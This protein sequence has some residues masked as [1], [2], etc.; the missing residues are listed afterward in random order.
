M[1]YH[2]RYHT[3]VCYEGAV[4]RILLEDALEETSK[5]ARKYKGNPAEGYEFREYISILMWNDED[6]VESQRNRTYG[7]FGP[8][9]AKDI[10]WDKTLSP[11]QLRL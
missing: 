4:S 9:L 2:R 5:K 8:L 10:S 6:M 11:Y 1:L 7:E 3:V